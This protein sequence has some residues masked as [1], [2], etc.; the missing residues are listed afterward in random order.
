M[1]LFSGRL[2]ATLRLYINVD[3]L[4]QESAGAGSVALERVFG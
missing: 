2:I 4:Q 3:V 1:L